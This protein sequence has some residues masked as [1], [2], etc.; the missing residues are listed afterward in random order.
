LYDIYIL[1]QVSIYFEF[2]GIYTGAGEVLDLLGCGAESLGEW[3]QT[4]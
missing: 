1:W 4:F 3:C 2:L